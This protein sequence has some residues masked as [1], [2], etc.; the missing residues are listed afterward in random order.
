M[1][2]SVLASG[3][4]QRRGHNGVLLEVN[5][6]SDNVNGDVTAT[7]KVETADL[8]ET[9]GAS[10]L[11]LGPAGLL[12]HCCQPG[13]EV[14]LSQRQLAARQQLVPTSPTRDRHLLIISILL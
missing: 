5:F 9:L 7:D 4:H 6:T 12:Y 3:R 1:F 13:G 14:V 2:H 8:A 11:P 10:E